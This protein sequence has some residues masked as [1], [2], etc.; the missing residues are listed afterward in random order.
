MKRLELNPAVTALVSQAAAV[1][2]PGVPVI[3]VLEVGGT[4]GFHVR[5]A[6]IDVYGVNHVQRDEDAGAHGRDER[7]GIRQFEE[8]ARFSDE[9]A[10]IVGR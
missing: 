5:Q 7:I 8:A 3:P 1:V 10:R 6:G 4:V 9:L 2:R